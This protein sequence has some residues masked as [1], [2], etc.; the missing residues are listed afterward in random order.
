MTQS[1]KNELLHMRGAQIFGFLHHLTKAQFLFIRSE[2]NNIQQTES[3][4]EFQ[5]VES[6]PW[7]DSPGWSNTRVRA[8]QGFRVQ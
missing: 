7:S 1:E 6:Y 2:K 8:G 5:E 3:S 4:A